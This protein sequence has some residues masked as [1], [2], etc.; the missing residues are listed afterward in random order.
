MQGPWD[1]LTRLQQRLHVPLLIYSRYLRLAGVP[2]QVI[3]AYVYSIWVYGALGILRAYSLIF[4]NERL[5]DDQARDCS[6]E[7]L[8]PRA[9][10]F[11][12]HPPSRFYML[13]ANFPSWNGLGES[14]KTLLTRT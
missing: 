8:L 12:A 14:R 3:Q 1:V 5:C 10:I 2:I 9:D 6:G 7:G 13:F 11:W 4:L